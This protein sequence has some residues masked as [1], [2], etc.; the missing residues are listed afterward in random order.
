[1][2]YFISGH[3][4]ITEDEFNAQYANRISHIIETDASAQFVVGDYYGVDVMAQKYLSQFVADVIVYHM[5]QTPRNNPHAYKT[6]GGFENDHDR[7]GAMTM[8]SDMDIAWVR[9]GREGSGTDQNLARRRVKN[10]MSK[11]SGKS[12]RLEFAQSLSRVLMTDFV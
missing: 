5:F 6:I 11:I 1:M 2:I 9:P 10:C 8:V 4:D 3:R 7:D 12:A